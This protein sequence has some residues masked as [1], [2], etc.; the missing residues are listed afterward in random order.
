MMRREINRLFRMLCILPLGLL[1]LSA[2]YAQR[3]RIAGTIEERSLVAL[4]GHVSHRTKLGND[5]VP[6]VPML[7]MQGITLH[8]KLSVAQQKAL[9][10]L[11]DD[12]QNP[13][14][15]LFHKWL[16][17]EQY[18]DRFGLSAADIARISTWLQ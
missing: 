14:S 10:Q 9:D 6:A 12:Q 3:D 11:L 16:S 2:A 4:Q 1:F 15:P 17:P 5:A 7:P 8:F 18:A 13:A